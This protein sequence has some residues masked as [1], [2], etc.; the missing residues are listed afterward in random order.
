MKREMSIRFVGF[1]CIWAL[2]LFANPLFGQITSSVKLSTDSVGLGDPITVDIKIILPTGVD[3]SGL[4]LSAYSKVQNQ[5]YPQDTNN[6]ER[7]ADLEVLDYGS[8]K[9]EGLEIPVSAEKLKIVDQ[10]GQKIISNTI[11]IAIYNAGLFSIS[12][13]VAITDD[14][15]IQYI[16]AESP[17]ISVSLPPNLMK[18]DTV[19][20]NPIKDIMR[21]EANFSD[22]LIYIYIL[23]GL[24]IIAAIGYYYYQLKKRKTEIVASIP[25][26]YIP[27]HEKALTAL[28]Q[29]DQKELWQQGFIK[30]Y[31]SGLTDI[32]RTYLLERYHIDAPEMT[33]DE[34]IQAL[35]KADFDK[36]YSQELMHILQIADLV[37]FA[38]AKPE[39][40]IHASFMTKA[41]DFIENTK[42]A[43][44]PAKEL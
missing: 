17:I 42:E 29:L 9:H 12:A 20:F 44:S 2:L 18:Q 41:V 11:K 30:D 36:K 34:I 43:R 23:A 15:N 38:K 31:Q 37:K 39:E 16:N 25:E 24:L 10:S 5:I 6:L 7:Y 32:V 27:C 4:D 26:I 14:A 35:Y 3:I 22:Y 28:K 19:I 8:W 33:T 13:P 40:N 1:W 21:E